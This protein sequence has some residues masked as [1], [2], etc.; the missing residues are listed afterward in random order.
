MTEK[1]KTEF[2]FE[3]E[4][5]KFLIIGI[6]LNLIGFFLM[7]GGADTDPDKF[8]ENGL[9]SEM[10]LT[11]APIVILLGYVVVIYSI[12]KKPKD[13]TNSNE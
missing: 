7:I 13:L 10:R 2:L 12:M 5:Y 8:N 3:K 4:N 1:N 9:F 6:A 11:V